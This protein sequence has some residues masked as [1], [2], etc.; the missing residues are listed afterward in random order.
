MGKVRVVGLLRLNGNLGKSPVSDWRDDPEVDVPIARGAFTTDVKVPSGTVRGQERCDI[1]RDFGFIQGATLITLLAPDKPLPAESSD[2][3]L[4]QIQAVEDGGK[5]FIGRWNRMRRS[6]RSH[7]L[8]HGVVVACP[9][10]YPAAYRVDVP[11]HGDMQPAGSANLLAVL[12]QTIP[13]NKD[14]AFSAS[15]FKL[16]PGERQPE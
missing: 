7:V 3:F 10:R 12:V 5:E 2:V 16:E 13:T 4:A 9:G 14:H 6:D 1:A 8:V 11:L 15:S